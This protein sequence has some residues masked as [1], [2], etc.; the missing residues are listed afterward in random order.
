MK[1]AVLMATYNGE[2]FLREQLDSVL[3]QTVSDFT[4]YISDDGSKDSTM[5]ILKEYEAKDNRIKLLCEHKPTGSS[6][7]NFLYLLENAQS[8]IYFFCDQDDVWTKDHIECLAN[9]YSKISE[10]EKLNPVLIHSDLTVVDSD[11]KVIAN[12]FFK[13]SNLPFDV[14][15]PHFYFVQNNVTGCVTMVNDVLK[16]YVFKNKKFLYENIENILMHDMLFAT[17]AAEF[18]TIKC[19][20]KSLELYRQHKNN[21]LGAESGNSFSNFIKKIFK[22]KEY[23]KNLKLYKNYTSWFAD[24]Y[25]Y[26]LPSEEYKI[27]KDFSDI[28]SMPKLKRLHFIKKHKFLRKGF[29]RNLWLKIAI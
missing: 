18:G 24:Y 25:E 2:K 19:I 22:I 11:L 14:K 17:I 7:K 26:E 5:Q 27:L 8:D 6:C 28:K 4:L 20:K 23:K 15:E 13:Y 21:I 12:S 16:N 29:I 1:L 9:E 3:S 10:E